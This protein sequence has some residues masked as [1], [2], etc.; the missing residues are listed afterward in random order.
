MNKRILTVATVCVVL[1]VVI[2][3]KNGT[4]TVSGEQ[5]PGEGFAAVPGLRGSQDIYGP[6]EVVQNWPKPMSESLAG[7]EDWTY[8]VTM[9]VF[10]ESPDRVFLVQKGELPLI[11]SRPESIW[12]PEL[13]PGMQYPNF[14]LPLRQA[15]GSIPNGDQLESE[16][17]GRP[18][19]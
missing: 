8:S 9:D 6:Y 12:L 14:R 10:A 11:E 16:G 15:G 7:H 2:W 5:V 4:D 18:G 13:G 17:N 3:L 19:I 1:L